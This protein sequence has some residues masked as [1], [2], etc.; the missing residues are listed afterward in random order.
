MAWFSSFFDTVQCESATHEDDKSQPNEA[1]VSSKGSE[2]DV[3]KSDDSGEEQ[4]E[5]EEKEEGETEAE[6]EEEEEAEPEDAMPA[7][8][9]ACQSSK[10][11][12]PLTQHFQ[13][14]QEKVQA[15]EGF[16]GEDCVEE[17]CT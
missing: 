3:E 15:G 7:I 10:S 1:V 9:E 2:D 5:T 4:E 12:A 11:C 17:L 6:E 13:H 16:K 8:R 14:C